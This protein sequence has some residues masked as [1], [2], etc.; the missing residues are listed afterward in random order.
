MAAGSWVRDKLLKKPNSKINLVFKSD[1]KDINSTSVAT[2]IKDYE[3]FE[4]G[5]IFSHSKENR[6]QKK[7]SSKLNPMDISVIN[8]KG[9]ELNI[10][11]MKS[12]FLSDATK[13]DFTMNALYFQLDELKILDPLESGL[14]DIEQGEIKLCHPDAFFEDP[15][16]ILRAIRFSAAYNFKLSEFIKNDI[17]GSHILQPIFDYT[18][19]KQRI[20][21]ELMKML[22]D[23]KTGNRTHD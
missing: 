19:N 15:L 18:V 4:N 9:Q 16:R 10:I 17:I 7:P 3:M 13:R 22:S 20:G 11:K 5:T 21:N 6:V 23:R 1:R 2:M 12:D 14:K 8:I